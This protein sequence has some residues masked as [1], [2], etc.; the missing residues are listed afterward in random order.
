MI[1]YKRLAN[2]SSVSYRKVYLLDKSA[3]VVEELFYDETESQPSRELHKYNDQGFEIEEINYNS[4]GTLHSRQ[5]FSDFKADSK[6]NW[7]IRKTKM[8][9][10]NNKELPTYA[11]TTYR[12]ISYH[13]SIKK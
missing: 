4:D 11:N 7:I 13:S 5:T 8:F 9:D 3:R 6:G 10:H 1:W 12:Q 2:E